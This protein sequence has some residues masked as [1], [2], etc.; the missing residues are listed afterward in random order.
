MKSKG[1]KGGGGP[2]AFR[3]LVVLEKKKAKT[4]FVKRNVFFGSFASYNN[5]TDL[6]YN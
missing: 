6:D 2:E 3:V 4:N 5:I 1:R